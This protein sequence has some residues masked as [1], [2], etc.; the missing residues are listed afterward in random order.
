MAA[1]QNNQGFVSPKSGGTGNWIGK[2][3]GGIGDA[4]RS[5]N[6]AQLKLNLHTLMGDVDIENFKTRTTWQAGSKDW[7]D[8]QTFERGGRAIT[9]G[10]EK[11]PELNANKIAGF[12]RNYMPQM[13]RTGQVRSSDSADTSDAVIE[14][15]KVDGK[16]DTQ[17]QPSGPPADRAANPARRAK[18][19]NATLKDTQAA[20]SAG[21]IDQ[22]QAA[23]M[24]PTYARNLGK[25]TASASVTNPD[26]P[27]TPAKVRTPRKPKG[28]A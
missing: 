22:E 28:G 2:L 4:R 8:E 15:V 20:L 19:R 24:S 12:D 5:Q 9:R 6:E 1:P 13:Q 14:T 16:V 27:A 10:I 11:G 3:F 7:L 23:E 25:K 18:A 17:Q 21:K 26:S